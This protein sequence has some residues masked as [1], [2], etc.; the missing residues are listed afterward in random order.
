M[1]IRTRHR[2]N[3]SSKGFFNERT[4]CTHSKYIGICWPLLLETIPVI[5]ALNGQLTGFFRFTVVPFFIK[6]VYCTNCFFSWI[7]VKTD[8]LVIAEPL[9][10]CYFFLHKLL[11][12]RLGNLRQ[13]LVNQHPRPVQPVRYMYKRPRAILLSLCFRM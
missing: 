2:R 4:K 9:F 12:A 6:T 10:Q 5:L 11:S 13:I 3:N 1:R 8:P 7:L